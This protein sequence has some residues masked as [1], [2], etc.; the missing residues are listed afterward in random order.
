MAVQEFTFTDGSESSP[1]ATHYFTIAELRAFRPRELENAVKYPD[2]K[3]D[4]A[5]S[6]AESAFEKAARVA[7]VPRSATTTLI[8]HDGDTLVVPSHVLRSVQAVTIDGVALTADQLSALKVRSWGGIVRATGWDDG[9]EIVVT[10]S[11]GYDAPPAPVKDAVMKLAVEAAI[12]SAIPA[13]ATAQNVG[14]QYFRIT[15]AGRDGHFGIPDVDLVL[16]DY[17][18]A[19]LPAVG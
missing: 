13:R 19:D 1:V 8:G 18:F 10:Y 11:H 3:L 16:K 12:P 5:R 14:D 6:V 9:A 17:G 2:A 7:F 4:E 15:V